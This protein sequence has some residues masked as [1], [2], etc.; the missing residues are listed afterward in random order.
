MSSGKR[1][2]AATQ[3]H[4]E[5]QQRKR[6]RDE[7]SELLQMAQG[8]FNMFLDTPNTA[9]HTPLTAQLYSPRHFY[10]LVAQS[11]A[12]HTIWTLGALD[13]HS[14]ALRVLVLGDDCDEQLA[15]SAVG[16]ALR[17][18][19]ASLAAEQQQ[20]CP[21]TTHVQ[22][23][24]MRFAPV[25]MHSPA[26]DAAAV[27]TLAA[28][29]LK[30]FADEGEPNDITLDDDFNPL[31]WHLTMLAVKA[32][33]PRFTGPPFNNIPKVIDDLFLQYYPQPAPTSAQAPMPAPQDDL[34]SRIAS[35][36]HDVAAQITK[37]RN[38]VA[39]VDSVSREQD[40]LLRLCSRFRA[41]RERSGHGFNIGYE[42]SQR[43][44]EAK[45]RAQEGIMAAYKDQQTSPEYTEALERER[46][47]RA[48][49]SSKQDQDIQAHNFYHFSSALTLLGFELGMFCG[50][51]R[52]EAQSSE[53][54]LVA[55]VRGLMTTT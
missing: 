14:S 34:L 44:I 33:A 16:E 31:P 17:Q 49:L 5:E 12:S 45:I 24:H 47:L 21:A 9:A 38:K 11:T 19:H 10:V 29:A 26:F 43:I 40:R 36:R 53:S 50:S 35:L 4:D 22:R 3:H 52:D 1:K 13:S 25:D 46:D 2:A 23:L 8:L 30:S 48:R 37:Y 27:S 15:I 39:L 55:A 54:V 42:N 20:P 51:C 18:S 28:V 6:L 41:E 32:L 7:D